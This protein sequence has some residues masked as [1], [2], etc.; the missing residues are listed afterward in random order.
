MARNS[1]FPEG[2]PM[3]ELKIRLPKAKLD[4]LRQLA[5]DVGNT[6]TSY[7]TAILFCHLRR[8]SEKKKDREFQS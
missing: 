1:T 3:A 7:A 4:E 5:Q 6:P 2:T 8:E